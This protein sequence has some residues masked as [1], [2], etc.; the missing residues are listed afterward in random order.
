MA[1][2]WLSPVRRNRGCS[3]RRTR[4]ARRPTARGGSS[5]RRRV[6][7]P[8]LVPQAVQPAL[9]AERLEIGVE[10]LGVVAHLSYD[11]VGP[12]VVERHHLADVAARADEA[13]DRGVRALC[14]LVDVLR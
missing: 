3:R 6:E 10:A 8:A 1:L 2:P 4:C 9:E 12:A 13:L 5:D 11:V 7:Q 14:P